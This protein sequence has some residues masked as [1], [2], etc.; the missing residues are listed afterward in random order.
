VPAFVWIDGAKHMYLRGP[1]EKINGWPEWPSLVLWRVPTPTLGTPANCSIVR[2]WHDHIAGGQPGTYDTGKMQCYG[3]AAVM[4]PIAWVPELDLLAWQYSGIYNGNYSNPVL[5]YTR[6]HDDGTSEAFGPWRCDLHSKKVNSALVPIPERFHAAL[7]AGMHWAAGGKNHT[8]IEGGNIGAG[9]HAIALPDPSTPPDGLYP[10]QHASYRA[11]S[12][13]DFDTQHPQPRAATA[14]T[15]LCNWHCALPAPPPG[16]TGIYDS[17]QGGPITLAAPFFSGSKPAAA[18]C[19]DWLDSFCWVETPTKRGIVFCGQV[20]S[21]APD[22]PRAHHWYGANPCCHGQHDASWEATGPGGGRVCTIGQ[23][24]DPQDLL[25]VA[26]RVRSPRSA[27]PLEEFFWNTICAETGI[28]A[29]CTSALSAI[30]W[31]PV[32][33][34]ITLT[35]RIGYMRN[36]TAMPRFF[37]FKVKG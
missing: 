5:G 21:S 26:R 36:Y 17:A 14:G 2:T 28:L 4:Y 24:F 9:L 6:L 35:Q 19:V 10:D 16:C 8:Q 37:V 25:P 20:N 1:C 23:I 33:T 12:L 22:G 27:E 31:D 11:L 3:E 15:D 13:I 7:P 34:T 18:S 32:D 30:V 29:G